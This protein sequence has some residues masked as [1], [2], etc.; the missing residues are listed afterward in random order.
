MPTSGWWRC[1][2]GHVWWIT[3]KK[4]GWIRWP[5]GV[6]TAHFPSLM[7]WLV[8]ID[9][10]HR[11]WFRQWEY[12]YNKMARDFEI[13]IEGEA[14]KSQLYPYWETGRAAWCV[15]DFWE[16]QLILTST[17]KEEAYSTFAVDLTSH[18]IECVATPMETSRMPC[19]WHVERVNMSHRISGTK[20]SWSGS[21]S[22]GRDTIVS[23]DKTRGHKY[24][25]KT[26]REDW[27]SWNGG[28]CPRLKGVKI[29]KVR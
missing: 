16:L 6:R 3:Y 26:G 8:E 25:Y 4:P 24:G 23:E 17:T 10:V 19:W 9:V 20:T 28:Q 18:I 15:W 22:Q 2:S 27:S 11:S 12:L 5:Q 7:W 13:V 14:I 1:A 21:M 29:G